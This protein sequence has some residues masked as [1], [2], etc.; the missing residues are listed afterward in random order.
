ML[1]QT[2]GIGEVRDV[3]CALVTIVECGDVRGFQMVVEFAAQQ[4]Y[5]RAAKDYAWKESAQLVEDH[6]QPPLKVCGF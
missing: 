2:R 4:R 1:L 6:S 5:A 3:L